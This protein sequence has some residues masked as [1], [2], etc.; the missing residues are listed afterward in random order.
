[1]Q[2]DKT[3]IKNIKAIYKTIREGIRL[4]SYSFKYFTQLVTSA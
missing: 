1:M 4:N 2:R 3:K